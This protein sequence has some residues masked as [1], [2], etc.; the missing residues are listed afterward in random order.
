[1]SPYKM[2]AKN[3]LIYNKNELSNKVEEYSNDEIENILHIKKYINAEIVSILK[4]FGLETYLQDFVKLV[5]DGTESNVKKLLKNN[6]EKTGV[7]RFILKVLSSIHDT[8]LKKYDEIEF[9]KRKNES[10]L[11]M[12]APF[13]LIGFNNVLYYFLYLNPIL[14]YIEVSYDVDYLEDAFHDTFK[15]YLVEKKIRGMEDIRARISLGNK[16]CPSLDNELSN[17]IISLSNLVTEEIVNNFK[18]NDYSSY[19][20]LLYENKK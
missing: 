15:N 12:Y 5:Y 18:D 14:D 16:Y 13:E 7:Y 2:I 6:V 3:I 8:Y 20:I 4:Y 19:E 1:M 10:K 17:R 9:I 11:N